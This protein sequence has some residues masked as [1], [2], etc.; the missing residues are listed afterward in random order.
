MGLATLDGE[1]PPADAWKAAAWLVGHAE[2]YGISSV[3]LDGREWVAEQGEWRPDHTVS[4][5][6]IRVVQPA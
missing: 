2:Q 4:G 5:G 6:R 1:L 3:A